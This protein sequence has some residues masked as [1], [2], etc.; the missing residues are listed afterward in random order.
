MKL[1]DLDDD[2]NGVDGEA[3]S[4]VTIS[5]ET[6]LTDALDIGVAYINQRR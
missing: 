5:A 1:A 4:A 3:Y 6:S 2:I